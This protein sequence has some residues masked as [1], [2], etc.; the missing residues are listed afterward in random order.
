MCPAAVPLREHVADLH[1]GDDLPVSADPFLSEGVDRGE[2]GSGAVTDIKVKAKVN[3][4]TVC[5]CY[6]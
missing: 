1:G 6:L 3:G 4:G 2:V 5:G